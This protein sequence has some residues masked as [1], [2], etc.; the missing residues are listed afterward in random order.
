MKIALCFIINY[1]HV[2]NKERIWREWI[3]HNKDIINVYFYYKDFGRIASKWI[4]DNVIP[5]EYI[6]P[7]SYLHV[8]PAYMSLMNYAVHAD[9]ENKWFIF[10]TDSCCPIIPAAKFR[11]MFQNYSEKS[12]IRCRRAWWNTRIHSR[13]NLSKLPYHLRLGNDPWFIL[14]RHHV[15]CCIDFVNK[16]QDI[17]KLVCDGGFANESLFA[18]ILYKQHES[19]ISE[20]TH[21]TDWSRIK[22]GTS[23]HTFSR[24]DVND[25][26]FI[27]K[28]L[29]DNK[30]T[31]FIRKVSSECP[32]NIIAKYLI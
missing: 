29:E 11:S 21:V 18:I 1:D 27:K 6:Y 16:Q 15:N 12:I 26:L 31:I 7:T 17:T 24:F 10:L 25:H 13:A 23:P 2:L 4:R 8:I 32:D 30:F 19:I 9:V 14:T 22:N 3:D 5:K 28:F 20:P